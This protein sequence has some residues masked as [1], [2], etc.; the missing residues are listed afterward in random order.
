[1]T[2]SK[3]KSF[4][5]CAILFALLLCFGIFMTNGSNIVKAE[6]SN[7][8][9]NEE[10]SYNGYDNLK[11]FSNESNTLQVA[12]I[13]SL[14]IRFGNG[15]KSITV[16]A[17][18]AAE[19]TYNNDIELQIDSMGFIALTISVAD[20]YDETKISS[21][22]IGTA[23]VMPLGNSYFILSGLNQN[24]EI[25]FSAE[26]LETYKITYYV[27][28]E[29]IDLQPKEYVK[30]KA[31]QL[32]EYDPVGYEFSGW[33][34]NKGLSGNP[35]TEI[36]DEETGDKKFY[37]KKEPKQYKVYLDVNGGVPL[38]QTSKDVTYND[39]FDLVVPTRPGYD[40]DG[41]FTEKN[42]GKQYTNSSGE[43]ICKWDVPNGL[44]LYAHW[45]QYSF[46]ADY[47]GYGDYITET[48]SRSEEKSEEKSLSSLFKDPVLDSTLI[49]GGWYLDETLNDALPKTLDEF[50][51]LSNAKGGM[52]YAKITTAY[53][54]TVITLPDK[55]K[56][57]YL[58][59]DNNNLGI[60]V[61]SNSSLTTLVLDDFV[62]TPK[63]TD[64]VF[65]FSRTGTIT[66]YFKGNNEIIAKNGTTLTETCASAIRSSGSIRLIS[67]NGSNI[68]IKGGG[69][70]GFL[71]TSRN[72]GFGINC[73]DLYVER[74]SGTGS[75]GGL[76]ENNANIVIMGGNGGSI[77]NAN[78]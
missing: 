6:T 65:D 76:G 58:G 16:A 9:C 44:T 72:G 36:S 8:E 20:G 45:S 77:T 53:S 15:I 47:S 75:Y 67:V 11:S 3:R 19:V 13:Y 32:A 60:K 46:T 33:Y 24:S 18:G 39:V 78:Y 59:K 31:T 38:S 74:S 34:D 1:M 57:F 48:I 66:I 63:T 22:I 4:V 17:T 71:N 69:M 56:R 28:D 62:T 64:N 5:V 54:N 21:N 27:D 37:G 14:W 49:F 7:T 29:P 61:T 50:D 52:L 35:I 23:S 41:W 10:L 42:G 25:I 70:D 12:A 55:C 68:K 43:S 40:F 30:G 2:N 26:K 51:K 73:T